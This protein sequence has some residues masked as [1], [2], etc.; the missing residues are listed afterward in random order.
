MALAPGTR[1]GPYK[2]TGQIG[3]GGMGQVYR[4]RDTKLDRD[5]AIKILPE[6]FAHN[7][8]RL[9]RFQREAKTLA[10]LNHPNIAGIYGLEES[11]GMTALVMELVEGDDLSYLIARGAIPIDEAL[12]IAKQ[13]AEALEAAHEQG[14][15]HRDLKPAN[16]KVRPDGTVKVLDLGLAKAIEL[17]AGSSPNVSQSAT[18]TSPAMT[19]A[20]MILGTAAYMSPEQ[21]AGKIADKRSDIW[22]F[23]VV[24]MEMLTGKPVFAGE[25]VSHV[26]AAVLR[27][28]PDWGTLPPKTPAPI[29]RALRR[30]LDKA[31][32]RRLDSAAAVRLE[33]EDAQTS[34]AVE[35]SPARVPR[36]VVPAT[37]ASV[38]GGALLAT[39]ALWTFTRPAPP[40]AAPLARFTITPPPALPL[41]LSLQAAARD[42]AVAPDGSFLVYRAGDAGQL[43][44]RWLDQLD[45]A[46]LTGIKSAVMPFVSPD[47][48]WVG[49]VQ[50][51]LALKKVAVTGGAP[52]TLARLPVWPRG[53][54]WV[55]DDTIIIGTNS[56][57]TGLLRVPAGGGEPAV[58]TTPDRARG[59]EGHVL[60]SRLPGGHGVLFTIGAAEPENAQIALLDLQTGTQTM[61]LRGGRDAQYVASGHLVYLS[62]RALAAARFDLSRRVVVGDPVRVIDGVAVTPTAA[63][64]VAV[65]E[66]GTLVFVPGGAGAVPLRSLAWVNRQGHETPIPAPPRPY[67]S[68]RLSPDGTRVAVSIRDQD[69]DVWTWDFARQTLTRLTFDADI[70]LVP[71]WTPDSRRIVFAS[72]RT[73]VYNLYARNVDGATQDV[74]LTTG[75]NTQLPDSLTPDGAFVIGHEVRLQTNPTLCESPQS[76]ARCRRLGGGGPCRNAIR[77]LERRDLAR[78]SLPGVPVGRVGP[79]RDLRAAVSACRERALAGVEWRR[80]PA[81]VDTRRARTGLSRRRTSPD[82]RAS[83]PGWGNVSRRDAGDAGHYDVSAEFPWRQYDV[84]PDGQRFLMIKED[85][86]KPRGASATSFVVVQN[87]FEEL[88]RLVPA[89]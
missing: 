73:G 61:L 87:W 21:A 16:I 72:A 43:V 33:L 55:D 67:E 58:L 80:R 64:N 82:G 89:K 84:S 1:L 2:V 20:G 38:F 7:A 5:V 31:P 34:P 60:P 69:N 49:F 27:A 10:S 62:G 68:A 39:L 86:I 71:V 47:S 79:E 52:V 78:R 25:M 41:S 6:A 29:R 44:V 57:T 14:I 85:A 9:A 17:G 35:V 48:K 28:D 70:D 50:D 66:A 83:R 88:K 4:A 11:E 59:E 15:I 18:T 36:R 51:N 56:L 65:T 77:R 13:I 63:L 76:G 54:S 40:P 26:L 19:Q 24:L 81:G 42:F 3:E 8:D 23:G 74:R 30:C 46:P 12:P 22:S 32:K 37:I 53:A 75:A 45:A